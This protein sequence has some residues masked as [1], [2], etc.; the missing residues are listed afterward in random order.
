MARLITAVF[1]LLPPGLALYVLLMPE[2]LTHHPAIAM[3]GFAAGPLSATAT[4]AVI[5]ALWIVSAPVLWGLWELK[6]LF[7]DYAAGAVFTV[8]A[9]QRLRRCGYAV[10]LAAARTVVGGVL[11]SAA[12][13]LD[14]PP[15][16]R[17]LVVSFSSDDIA[18]LL[19]GGILLVIARVMEE[20]ARI[21][22][23][24]AAFV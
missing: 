20:A 1:W 15:G 7:E 14:R 12:L 21:A 3:A 23:E 19:I 16:A 24:N 10:M 5:A 17:A 11:M 2:Q 22:A 13:S 4:A 8:G 9:A 18:L 6:R